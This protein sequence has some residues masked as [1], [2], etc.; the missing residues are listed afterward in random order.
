[1]LSHRLPALQIFLTH[2]LNSVSTSAQP[3]AKKA[4]QD[5][6]TAEDCDHADAAI[7][8]FAQPYGAKFAKAVKKITDD[9]EE[10]LVFFDFPAEH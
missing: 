5:S 8:A 1:M 3:G 4:I 7:K 10:L 9:Q 2:V 6:Y